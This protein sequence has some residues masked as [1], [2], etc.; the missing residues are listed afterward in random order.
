MLLQTHTS[1]SKQVDGHALMV[2]DPNHGSHPFK[3]W[4][5]CI[6]KDILESSYLDFGQKSHFI[7][8]AHQLEF[9]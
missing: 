5:I 3:D 6:L 1:A 2:C 7:S 9:L 8:L 4:R